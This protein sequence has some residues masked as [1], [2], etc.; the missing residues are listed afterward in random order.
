MFASSG[1]DRLNAFASPIIS[2]ETQPQPLQAHKAILETSPAIREELR[3]GRTSKLLSNYD[4]Y[5]TVNM[6]LEFLYTGRYTLPPPPPNQIL[7]AHAME[8]VTS[9]G[10]SEQHI[11][12]AP[13]GTAGGLAPLKKFAAFRNLF[14]EDPRPTQEGPRCDTP[15]IFAH[16]RL[17]ILAL[18]TGVVDL[19]RFA[20][21]NL[22]ESLYILDPSEFRDSIG[23]LVQLV[24]EDDNY[25]WAD[26]SEGD[27]L[28][29]VVS[30]W[31]TWNIETLRGGLTQQLKAGGRFVLDFTDLTIRRLTHPLETNEVPE[32]Q[33]KKRKTRRKNKSGAKGGGDDDS[34]ATAEPR[35]DTFY[36]PQPGGD[37]L[38]EPIPEVEGEGH[39]ER[40]VESHKPNEPLNLEIPHQPHPSELQSHSPAADTD[41][42]DPHPKKESEIPT[43][44]IH[45]RTP[46]D[47]HGPSFRQYRSASDVEPDIQLE[48]IA[49]SSIHP[50]WSSQPDIS[51]SVARE[52]EAMAYQQAL[53]KA[54]R[55]IEMEV[56]DSDVTEENL[57]AEREQKER[58]RELNGKENVQRYLAEQSAQKERDDSEEKEF[59]HINGTIEEETEETGNESPITRRW[60]SCNDYI[61]PTK[62]QDIEIDSTVND[63]PVTTPTPVPTNLTTQSS[64]TAQ[65]SKKKTKKRKKLSRLWHKKHG[66]PRGG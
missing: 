19:F 28:R 1:V 51:I 56:V 10:P 60:T 30:V 25:P 52:E 43:T 48:P 7:D 8:K 37:F 58:E 20:L 61:G 17:A 57:R 35:D 21:N 14:P 49:D 39:H 65:N 22:V 15:A 12:D 5:K 46:N 41:D 62:T 42:F 23:P 18:R 27:K 36:T 24:Y 54:K 16:T 31:V 59:H 3:S 38:V 63:S 6:F 2:I 45:E 4:S 64:Q 32:A 34:V 11:S 26:A 40:P 13:N 50:S 66:S 55:E 33:P 47:G 53:A 9:T 44:P 29:E